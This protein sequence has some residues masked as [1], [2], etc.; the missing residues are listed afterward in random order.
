MTPIAI[1]LAAS[2]VVALL[3]AGYLFGARRGVSARRLLL[4]ESR[5]QQ[6]RAAQ[7]EAKLQLLAKSSEESSKIREHLEG[8]VRTLE[9]RSSEGTTVQALRADM[10]SLARMIQDREAKDTAMRAELRS[11]I[12]SIAKTNN[13][14]PVQLE[15]ELRRIVVPLLERQNDTKGLRE[16]VQSTLTPMLERERLGR[17]LAQIE[18]GSTLHELPRLLDG[19]AQKGGFSSVVLSDDVGLPLAASSTAQSV[20]WLAGMASLVLT[21][22]ERAERASEPRPIGVVVHDESNQMLLHRIFRVGSQQFLLTAVARGIEV[23]PSALDPALGKLERALA[24]TEASA[25]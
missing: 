19:I 24:R 5:H 11:E 3:L 16:L 2:A 15:R 25:A 12:V 20:D 13:N 21:L 22:V 14:N 7:L 23:S 10:H 17:E 1:A 18:G 6:Q 9:Q 4:T 8:V